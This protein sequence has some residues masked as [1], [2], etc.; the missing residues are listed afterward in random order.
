M[1]KKNTDNRHQF[2]SKQEFMEY[3]DKKFDGIIYF[4][5]FCRG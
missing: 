5:F 1:D 3:K 4:N 2:T